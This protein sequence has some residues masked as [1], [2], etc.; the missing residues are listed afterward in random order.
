MMQ[1][2]TNPAATQRRLS[3]T[4]KLDLVPAIFSILSSGFFSLFSGI[5]R[6]EKGA[7]TFFLHV[8]Y[9][10]LRKAT[11]RLSVLQFQ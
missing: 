4:E 10:I 6:G 11:R 8:A 3:I 1:K 7:P 9:A 5:S 2:S